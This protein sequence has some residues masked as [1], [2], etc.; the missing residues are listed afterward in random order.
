MQRRK[1]LATTAALTTTAL[2]GCSSI[3]GD[4][5]EDPDTDT[6]TNETTEEPTDTP[7]ETPTDTPTDEPTDEPTET[8]TPTAD[9]PEDAIALL[10]SSYE[11][12]AQT[13]PDAFLETVHSTSV[14]PEDE[15][16]GSV[17][18]F[19]GELASIEVTPADENNWQNLSAD[20]LEGIFADDPH[21]EDGDF[22]MLAEADNLF[23]TVDA[24]VEGE[25]E[26]DRAQNFK[27][28]LNSPSDHFLAV[29]DGEWKLV[30]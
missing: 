8:E 20:F 1:L 25:A 6:P 19:D 16:R 26:T 18:D 11:A 22:E 5:S 2:A 15:V 28:F 4:N 9:V 23:L 10:E 24:T 7:T 21:F 17:P 27:D 14:Y 30:S 3:F 12:W 13:D 29:E